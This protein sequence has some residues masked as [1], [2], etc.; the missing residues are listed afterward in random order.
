MQE[1]WLVTVGSKACIRLATPDE[2]EATRL[3]GCFTAWDGG[4]LCYAGTP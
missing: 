4:P 2:I 3:Y 1:I